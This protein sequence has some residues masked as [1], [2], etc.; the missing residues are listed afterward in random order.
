LR[1]WQRLVAYRLL[2][3]DGE[4]ELVWSNL[5]LTTAR[6][7]G[8]S[9]LL[10]ELALW[11][12]EQG[13]RFGE[14]Q[15]VMMTG[16]DLSVLREIQRPARLWAKQREGEY[17]VREAQG[18]E[19][20]AL[21]ADGSR[22][23]IRSRYAVYGYSVS[24][25]V[26]DEGWAVPESTV[27]DGLE[28]TM[29]ERAAS[30]L[31]VF[32]T[33]HRLATD[34]VRSRRRAALE[35]IASP[36]EPEDTLFLEWSAPPG[37][38]LDDER[39]W[40]WASPH[41]TPRREKMVRAKLRRALAGQRDDDATDPDPVESFRSQWL[42]QWPADGVAVNT[43]RLVAHGELL[44]KGDAPSGLESPVLVMEDNLGGQGCALV[45]AQRVGELVA[46]TSQTYDRREEAWSYLRA[47]SAAD[48]VWDPTVL[49]GAT[50]SVDPAAEELAA[51]A[52]GSRE[53]RPAVGLF[54][55][56][57]ADGRLRFDGTDD[58]LTTALLAARTVDTLT[59]TTLAFVKGGQGRLDIVRA[60]LWAVAEAVQNPPEPQVVPA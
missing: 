34:L 19:E 36:A 28:P 13:P 26:V 20:V 27:S 59:G 16:K 12:I 47:V 4:G 23:M 45:L 35:Q 32:S 55:D 38:A 21:L 10:A 31:W 37:M 24:V 11:R 42:N 60:V 46:V 30:Q 43:D 58:T 17:K 33:A 48:N 5:I 51:E 2:E 50:L 1:W 53:L 6:Q 15:L 3:V 44:V 7:S 39:G 49:V 8:K 22:F 14:P 9:V 52:R 40:H 18:Q 25:G 41:W 54:R 56:L 57:L 29:A